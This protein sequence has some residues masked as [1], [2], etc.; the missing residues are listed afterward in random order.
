MSTNSILKSSS[1]SSLMHHDK[2]G[3]A[4]RKKAT[5][6][7]SQS[8]VASQGTKS[9]R[10]ASMYSQTHSRSATTQRSSRVSA[11]WCLDYKFDINS[12]LVPKSILFHD[13]RCTIPKSALDLKG[14]FVN[15]ALFH[16]MNDECRE[17][18][19]VLIL[20]GSLGLSVD[21]LEAIRGLPELRRISLSKAEFIINSRVAGIIASFRTLL[22][23]DLSRCESN[24][25]AFR[26]FSQSCPSVKT[27]TLSRCKGVED[28]SARAIGQWIQRHRTLEKLDLSSCPDLGDNG[29]ID[30]L[31]A[32]YNVLTD[33]NLSGC[34]GINTVALTALRN[35]NPAIKAL[36]LSNMAIDQSP[37]EWITEGCRTIT[38]LDI[39]HSPELLDPLL[40]KIGRYCWSLLHLNISYC[41]QIS[42]DGITAFFGPFEGALVTLDISG[43]IKCGSTSASTISQHATQLQSLKLNGLARVD[44]ASLTALWN[45]SHQLQHFEMCSNLKSTVTHRKSM[46]PHFSDAV[47]TSAVSPSQ[48]LLH[49]KLSG[50][51]QVTD[52]GACA[53]V[54]TSVRLNEI[55]VSYCHGITDAL[56]FAVAAHSKEL[57]ALKVTGC[58]NISDAGVIALSNGCCQLTLRS[59]ELN[60]CRKV[61]DPGVSAIT[62]LV[63]LETLG[64][65]SCDYTTNGPILAVAESCKRL[66]SVEVSNLDYID[67]ECI[68][69]FATHCPD[70]TALGAEGCNLTAK[71]FNAALEQQLPFAK[72]ISNKC[73]LER[74]PLS[75]VQFNK[76][77]QVLQRLDAACRVIQKFARFI[78]STVLLRLAKKFKRKKLMDTR[79]AFHA[80]KDALWKA[81]ADNRKIFRHQAA[82]D[83]QYCMR[84]LFAIRLARLHART[85][86]QQRDSRGLL[87]RFFRGYMSRKRTTATATRLYYYYNQ[88]GYLVHKYIIV[89]AARRLHRQILATQGFARM[90]PHRVPYRDFLYALGVLQRK[91][92]FYKERMDRQRHKEFLIA[93]N[94]RVEAERRHVAARILQ[95]NLK[96]A[97]FNKQMAPYIFM[98]CIY[99]RSEY[100]EQKWY[101]TMLQRYWRGYIVRLHKW[102]RDDRARLE[103]ESASRI[104][105]TMKGVLTR[106]E[107]GPRL[108]RFRRA[109]QAWKRFGVLGRPRLRLGKPT[110]VLQRLARWYLFMMDRHTA[111]TQIQTMWRGEVCRRKWVV[112]IRAMQAEK[113][114]IIQSIFRRH[115]WRKKRYEMYA[116]QKMAAYKIA[117]RCI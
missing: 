80:F 115:F 45:A 31:L 93:E 7:A 64:L 106:R 40:G 19:R 107:M 4:D 9:T 6:A 78:I 57:R 77:V 48:T 99:Y 103:F 85:L 68:C 35:R 63:N 13:Y 42:D 17:H 116:R 83:L 67:V 22:H 88:I 100:D 20:E 12:L 53:V 109:V 28:L 18:V 23:L 15:E 110:A 44:A 66:Q 5:I 25:Q 3:F 69:A 8:S 29:V 112:L 58:I 111:A 26:I 41:D 51:F 56:L 117:V 62:R 102:R 61:K 94:L 84:R 59:L 14:W 97:L 60:G 1:M 108:Q 82:A 113:A 33:I 65:R 114:E 24:F 76:Y 89:Q 38:H 37:F 43:C 70:L 21:C 73:R 104:A 34:R 72:P 75:V 81:G 90:I 46:M 92:R 50:A 47:L 105:A 16:M 2:S 71:E 96:A 10:H 98:C 49:L 91:W 79:R 86:R 101:S 39:S 30:L 95:R 55:D 74:Y 52:K 54:E 36:N 32:G 11:P 27:L 87:Q